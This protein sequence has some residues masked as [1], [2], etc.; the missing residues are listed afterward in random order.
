MALDYCANTYGVSPCTA[1]AAQKCYNT[2]PTCR[3]RADYAY[4]KPL[5]DKVVSESSDQ[6]SD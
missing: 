3:S 4:A 1:T 2:Y 5:Y 6:N